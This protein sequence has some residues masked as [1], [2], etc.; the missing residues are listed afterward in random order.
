ME[1]SDSLSFLERLCTANISR[2]VG[3]CV[4]TLMLNGEGGIEADLVVSRMDTDRFYLTIG[5]AA[6]KYVI[7]HLKKHLK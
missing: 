4:Y 5:S 2:P 7:R 3:S 6:T 1:G